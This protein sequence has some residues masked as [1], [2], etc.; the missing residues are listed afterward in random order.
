M[1]KTIVTFFV[2]LSVGAVNGSNVCS[3]EIAAFKV[4]DV[5]VSPPIVRELTSVVDLSDY[6]T[7]TI[8]IEATVSS[9][10]AG[11]DSKTI[12][13]VTF[14]INGAVV[15]KEKVAPFT[16]FGNM[17]RS[18]IKGSK[19]P[20]GKHTLKACTYSDKACTKD[21]SGCK[22]VDVEVIDCDKPTAAPVLDSS[23]NKVVGFEVVNITGPNH[24]VI[25]PFTPP[26]IDLSEFPSCSLNIIATVNQ[27][28]IGGAP[29]KCVEMMLGNHTRMEKIAPYALYGN[30]KQ[31]FQS[32]QPKLGAQTLKACTYTDKACTQGESGCLEVA[33]LVKNCNTTTIPAPTHSPTMSPSLKPTLMPTTKSAPTMTCTTT[34]LSGYCWKQNEVVALKNLVNTSIEDIDNFIDQRGNAIAEVRGFVQEVRTFLIAF[35]DE[36]GLLSQNLTDKAIIAVPMLPSNAT[37]F[38]RRLT[39]RELKPC[40]DAAC[41]AA[42]INLF[43]NIF[44]LVFGIAGLN[45]PLEL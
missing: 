24:T 10:P 11:C 19:P 22:E 45:G 15:R 7:C 23:I 21:E 4:L 44:D 33:V 29:I 16:Y 42:I 43:L 26:I 40:N 36:G 3:N 8:D 37:N 18:S 2:T 25:T 35:I 9:S 41:N 34:I 6:A 12:K 13:C 27:N 1:F 31:V 14:F 30:A 20:I 28:T 39:S 38:S 17:P 5:S 32:G